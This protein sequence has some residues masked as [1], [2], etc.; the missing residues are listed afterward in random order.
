MIGKYV[1]SGN[2]STED[3]IGIKNQIPLHRLTNGKYSIGLTVYIAENSEV[4]NAASVAVAVKKLWLNEAPVR[5]KS[6]LP[7]AV[8]L[9]INVSP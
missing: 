4:P 9:P 5:L 8:L 6:P 1:R 3:I 2:T 7:S